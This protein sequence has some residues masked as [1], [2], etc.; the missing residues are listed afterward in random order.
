LAEKRRLKNMT[1]LELQGKAQRI[2]SCSHGQA[3]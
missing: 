1:D 3:H 2:L